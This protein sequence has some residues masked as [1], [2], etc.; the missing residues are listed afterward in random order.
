MCNAW[1]SY[2]KIY[3]TVL[4]IVAFLECQELNNWEPKAHESWIMHLDSWLLQRW[5]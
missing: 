5:Y 2:L 1:I 3:A 4:G